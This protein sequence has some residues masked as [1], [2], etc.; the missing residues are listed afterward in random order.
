M[1]YREALPVAKGETFKIKQL[2]PRPIPNHKNHIS[3]EMQSNINVY[4]DAGEGGVAHRGIIFIHHQEET[5]GVANG[6]IEGL[7]PKMKG[8]IWEMNLH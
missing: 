4:Q 5:N 6:L 3:R 7:L 1:S 2:H 8:K